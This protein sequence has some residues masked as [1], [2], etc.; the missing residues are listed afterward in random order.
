MY[1]VP[2]FAF[3]PRFPPLFRPL[4][5]R[6]AFAPLLPPELPFALRKLS[7]AMTGF[8]FPVTLPGPL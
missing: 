1:G 2:L 5:F 8:S 7:F 3:P 6:A 4:F